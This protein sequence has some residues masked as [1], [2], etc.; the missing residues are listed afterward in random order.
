MSRP[1]NN[2]PN[3]PRRSA[4]RLIRSTDSH[5]EPRLLAM[6]S[7]EPVAGLPTLDP[8][9]DAIV[10]IG[11]PFHP[12]WILYIASGVVFLSAALGFFYILYTYGVTSAPPS[13]VNRTPLPHIDTFDV[14]ATAV[15]SLPGL[16]YLYLAIRVRSIRLRLTRERNAKHITITRCILSTTSTTTLPLKDA[17]LTL[18]PHSEYARFATVWRPWRCY[19]LLLVSPSCS[20]TVLFASRP[21]SSESAHRALD[22]ARQWM[23]ATGLDC[24]VCADPH[25][26]ML[27]IRSSSP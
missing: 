26:D 14:V 19:T 2:P 22:A 24:A 7:P 18:G 5:P 6:R 25:L 3:S 9:T 11:R 21:Q 1:A 4:P 13:A 17:T 12:M 20:P 23:N 15:L 16:L 27:D 8:A 10:A